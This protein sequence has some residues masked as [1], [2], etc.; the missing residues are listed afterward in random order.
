MTNSEMIINQIDKML[1]NFGV[2]IAKIKLGNAGY[3]EVEKQYLSVEKM[4]E[5]ID[6]INA[7]EYVFIFKVSSPVLLVRIDKI[8][9]SKSPYPYKL[10]KNINLSLSHL[11]VKERLD[12]WHIYNSS[13]AE[14]IKYLTS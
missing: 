8:L 3:T 7:E 9:V 2:T 4:E 12:P 1:E 11:S 10:S 14:S 6:N 13:L 5:D